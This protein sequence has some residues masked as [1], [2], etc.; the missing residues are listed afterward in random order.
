MADKIVV[1][2][3]RPY[4]AGRA[5]RSRSMTI[6]CN[7]FVAG[8]IGSPAMN[9]VSGTLRGDNGA[10]ACGDR[11]WRGLCRC[12]RRAPGQAG[13]AVYYGVRPDHLT[14]RQRHGGFEATVDVVEPTGADTLVFARAGNQKICGAFA[15]RYSFAGERIALAPRLDCVH[16]FDAQSGVNLM[17]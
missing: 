13:Q 12:R 1:M 6:R 4:R 15:E 11:G 5:R 16:L 9:L 3:G 14:C 10:P 7:L 2:Q 17:P 8:F